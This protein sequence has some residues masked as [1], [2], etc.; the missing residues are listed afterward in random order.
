[1]S[2]GEAPPVPLTAE[3]A[4]ALRH[5]LRTPVNHIVGYAEMLREDVPAGSTTAATLDTILAV[6]REV[7]ERINAALPPTGIATESGLAALLRSLRDPQQRV[8]EA[9]ITLIRGNSDPQFADDVAKIAEAAKRLTDP[10]RIGPGV[11]AHQPAASARTST[12]AHTT[13]GQ[14][15]A[16]ARDRGHAATTGDPQ[17]G[18]ILIVDDVEENR[19]VLARRLGREG[20]DVDSVATGEAALDRIGTG[21]FDLVL[22]DVL[23]PGMD[24]FA[25]L[26]RIKSNPETRRIPVIMISALDDL[27][28]VVRC[29]EHGAEDYLA[30]PFDPVL[31]RA[32]IGASLEKKRWHDREADYLKQ[33]S[34]VI[35]AAGAV[36]H[37]TYAAGALGAVTARDDEL[38][39]LARVFDSMAAGIRAREVKLREQ[40]RELRA[41]VSI[42]TSEF[43]STQANAANEAADVLRLGSVLANRYE[44]LAVVGRG[45]MGIVYRARDRELNEDVAIKAIRQEFLADTVA[46]ER[47]KSEIRL[48][49]RISHR[50]V[51]RTHDLGEADGM[52]FVTMEY[53]RG[54]D[55]R[56]LLTTRGKLGVASTIALARQFAEALAVAHSAGVIHRDVKPE[57]ALIDSEGVL[58]VMDFGIARLAEAT[59]TR[60]QTGMIVGTPA[61]MAPE[62]LVGEEV[63]QRA[64]LYALG[65]VMYE[66]L[67]GHA[68]FQA[69]SAVALIGKVLT[70]EAPPPSAKSADVPPAL[71]ALVMRLLSKSRDDR[72]ENAGAL[73]EQLAELG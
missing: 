57:N 22:L 17:R 18:R 3:S 66:C 34:R 46:A 14:T 35:D 63:D 61:Y 37:G 7:L 31:L 5:E 9:T 10:P 56:E 64:D 45:G 29:I 30:K 54:I 49:R 15:E 27:S 23:M 73:I 48:A 70:T 28:S 39:R 4:G 12:P 68:P 50:N 59:S 72:P 21:A 8:L 36:E 60:T 52:L 26:E 71:S 47:F 69:P 51:V 53:V 16:G 13:T 58:K 32:R 41:D 42:A 40:L 25:V 65:V 19:A 33:V 62:Q 43:E 2:D 55:V 6:A 44:V 20:Y 11:S 1:M 67:A 38:G 24:G